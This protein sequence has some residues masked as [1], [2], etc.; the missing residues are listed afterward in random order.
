MK[1]NKNPWL[2]VPSQY[3]AE[4]LPY[5]IVN[6]MS[7]AMFKSMG[8]SNELIGLTSYL[9]LPWAI[10][11]LWSPLVDSKSTKRNW[12]L[13]MQLIMA[14]L[15]FI[16]AAIL[17][18]DS[19]FIPVLIILTIISFVSATHDIATDGS[20]LHSLD[21][22]DQAFFSGIRNTFY[23]LA[24]IF[25]SGILVIIAGDIT[26]ATGNIELGWITAFVIVGVLLFL[27]FLY[28]L[29]I[30]PKPGTDRPVINK[31][32]TIPFVEAFRIYFSRKKIVIVVSFILLYRFGEALL[33]KMAPAF[34]LDD[35]SL[36]GLGVPLSDF[37]FM[38]GTL[39]VIAL[40]I[41]GILG[42]ILIKRYSLK[43]L[44]WPMAIAMNLPNVLYIILAVMQPDY[45]YKIDL[46]SISQ[47]FG[48][49]IW[50]I[51]FYPL[52]QSFVIIEQFGYG[53]GFTAFM[54]YLLY[55]SEGEYKT[56]LYAISTGLMAV[57]MMIPGLFS[58]WVQSISSYSL[59]FILSVVLTIPGMVFIKYLPEIEEK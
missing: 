14:V 25:G 3:F 51:N 33:V 8:V 43:R 49:E 24:V 50:N 23:R 30:L 37:G 15:F 41:G 9:Y 19:N 40:V 18:L 13:A 54:V 57:G 5:I 48:I 20:Y 35:R 27:I 10:K 42:G 46:S 28:H 36:G 1:K 11:P 31:D 55:I 47:M 39:G 53:L 34:I 2:F 56:S 52:V 26:E 17:N 21:K 59:L 7:V 16:T 58:G 32:K 6:S 45:V 12:V 38:Y 22:G 29:F 44:I 4:G